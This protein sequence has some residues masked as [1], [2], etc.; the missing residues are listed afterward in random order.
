MLNM[1][2]WLEEHFLFPFIWNDETINI[3]FN[4]TKV[5]EDMLVDF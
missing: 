2:I 1:K 3:T 4:I 5:T